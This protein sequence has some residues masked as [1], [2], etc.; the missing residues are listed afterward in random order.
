MGH[1]RGM[2]SPVVDAPAAAVK[3]DAALVAAIEVAREAVVSDAGADMV[4]DHLGVVMEG[5]RL[6]THAFEC[7]NPAYVG[8]QWAVTVARAPR[9][10]VVTVSEV[11]LLPGEQA[12]VAPEWVPWSDR[13]QAGDLAPGDVLPTTADDPRLVAG[14]TGADDL[15]SV[16]S[17]APLQPSQ[18][19]LGLGRVRVLSHVGRDDAADRW[20]EGE[21][22]PSS[23][24]AKQ[25]TLECATC[26]FML[27]MDGPMGQMFAV[28]AN[29]Y[30][31]ADGRVVTL[32]YGCGAHSEAMP[33][34]ST[35][36]EPGT[37]VE[38]VALVD[39]DL[40]VDPVTEDA[41]V[42][43]A[44]VGD[45]VEAE[46]ILSEDVPA[47]AIVDGDAQDDAGAAPQE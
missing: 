13:I 6:A 28:C 9:A 41:P 37:G 15:E 47:E 27:P 25:A 3:K 14:L 26:G 23:P 24:M 43:E 20:S 21:F 42:A 11:V 5:E 8:W 40:D 22:G 32:T 35:E 44:V 16:A 12:L 10:K 19:E 31:P 1:N 36:P 18:W 45:D 39:E 34:P 38:V 33:A 46:E 7:R 17:K 30:S 2:E 29:E 4:G